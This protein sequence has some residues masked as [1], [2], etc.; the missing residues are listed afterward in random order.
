MIHTQVHDFGEAKH[1]VSLRPGRQ[2]LVA[3]FGEAEQ[4]AD[5]QTRRDVP[6]F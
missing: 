5:R 3:E 4:A 1:I 2:A 6:R